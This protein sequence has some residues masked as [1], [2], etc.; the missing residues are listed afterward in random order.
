MSWWAENYTPDQRRFILVAFAVG[1]LVA[2][3]IIYFGL[4]G[5]LLG[6]MPGPVTP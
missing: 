3:L 4:S 1:F 5:I 2:G 6:G